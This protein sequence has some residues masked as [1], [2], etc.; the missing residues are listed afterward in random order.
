VRVIKSHRAGV[1]K[2]LKV[3][4]LCKRLEEVVGKTVNR[5]P[6]LVIVPLHCRTVGQSTV[7]EALLPH[8]LDTDHT[9]PR[10]FHIDIAHEVCGVNLFCRWSSHDWE[11]KA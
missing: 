9:V 5:E 2:T 10:I 3:K 6:L 8:T 7:L 11:C 4:R 1:G